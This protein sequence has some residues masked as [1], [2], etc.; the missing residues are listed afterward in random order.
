MTLFFLRDLDLECREIGGGLE[1]LE[2]YSAVSASC[3]VDRP[4]GGGDRN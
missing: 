3:A 2:G 1:G 4:E